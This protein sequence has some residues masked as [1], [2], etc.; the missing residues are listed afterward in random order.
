MLGWVEHSE[1]DL[2][3][4]PTM[5]V[6]MYVHTC[7]GWVFSFPLQS[8]RWMEQHSQLYEKGKHARGGGDLSPPVGV[9]QARYAHRLHGRQRTRAQPPN[10][11]VPPKICSSIPGRPRC[12]SRMAYIGSGVC[13]DAV[14]LRTKGRLPGRGE[15]DA[16]GCLDGPSGRGGGDRV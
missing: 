4:S 3:F 16:E 14:R 12:N 11:E 6:C 8:P 2:R 10:G 5:Y 15:Q 9:R 7:D 1:V 13:A